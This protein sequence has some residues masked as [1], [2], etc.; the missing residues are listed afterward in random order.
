M[1]LLIRPMRPADL[2]GV[3]A[4][5]CAAYPSAYHEPQEALAS[6]LEAGRAHCFVAESPQGL[7]GYVFAH[8]WQGE[9]PLLHQPLQVPGNASHLF[10]H[11][12]AIAPAH[13]GRGL[14]AA[15]MAAIEQSLHALHVVQVRLV[16]VGQAQHFWA[17][18]GFAV[19]QAATPPACYGQAVIMSRARSAGCLT[20]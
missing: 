14:A 4:V 1:S 13:Q 5:Q 3:W 20:P 8:P 2:P 15:L 19:D 18:Y 10:I 17:R 7:A 9:P 16:A 6:H 12:M 11:D